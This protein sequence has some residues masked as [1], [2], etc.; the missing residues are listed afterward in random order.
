MARTTLRIKLRERQNGRC[1]Y[2]DCVMTPTQGSTKKRKPLPT[3]ETLEHLHRTVEGGTSHADNMALACYSCNT[4]RGSIDWLTYTSYRR[5]EH[6][7]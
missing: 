3:S 5:G 2:C 6:L 1:C 7:S 4:G